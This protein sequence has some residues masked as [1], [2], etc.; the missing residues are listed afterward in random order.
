MRQVLV[1]AIAVTI[2][3]AAAAGPLVQPIYGGTPAQVGDYPTVV[4]IEL[5]SSA[6]CTG[7]LIHPSYVLTAAH[8]VDPEVIG[9]GTQDEVTR[10]TKVRFDS[11]TAFSGTGRIVNAARTIP[12]PAFSEGQLGDDDIGLIE[13][14]QPV[15]DRM[16]SRVNRVAAAAPVGVAVTL[17]GFGKDESNNVGIEQVLTNHGSSS[18]ST[19]GESDALLLCFSQSDGQGQCQGDSGGPSFVTI[20]GIQ[21]VT[22]ITS[23]GDIDCAFFGAQTRVDA[24]VA[25]ADQQIGASLKCVHDGVCVFG[26]AG[27]SHDADC[28][29]CDGDGDCA[30]AEVCDVGGTCVPAPLTAG[31]LGNPC[32]LGTEC[33]TG[34]CV[35]DGTQ[36]LCSQDCNE[37]DD[38][39]DDFECLPTNTD[40]GVCWPAPPGKGGCDGAGGGQ[41]GALALLGLALLGLRRRARPAPSPARAAQ[42]ARA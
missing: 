19:W 9:V 7:T 31:G 42:R 41:G 22:G 20:D 27:L 12:N 17:V 23:F 18:C 1:V 25:F 40:L 3:A 4:V 26:C 8:C 32:T 14:A 13:L 28:A 6:L 34:Q 37:D 16:V 2:P 29:L 38:C 15:D 21:T 10:L 39:G 11:V 33:A 24:E 36:M 35:N 5:G 30:D